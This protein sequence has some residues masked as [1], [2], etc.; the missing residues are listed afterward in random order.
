M[1]RTGG[2]QR[3]S[4]LPDLAVGLRRALHDRGP[5]AGLRRRR[6]R[7]GAPRVRQPDPPVRALTATTAPTAPAC[8]PAAGDQRR[9]LRPAAAR[10]PR[11]RRAVDR[12]AHR[13]RG[14][15]RRASRSSG[16]SA[17]PATRR[18]RL[19]RASR[20]RSAIVLDAARP[21]RPRRQR[22]APRRD[23][24]DPRR[25]RGV[26]RSATRATACRP[27]SRRSSAALYVVAAR[28]RRP[29]RRRGARTPPASAPLAVP[30]RASAAGS[31]SS[32]WRVGLRHRRVP[33]RQ[34]VRPARSS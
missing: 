29:A 12:R 4:Q 34:A 11:P 33:R 8:A 16:C 23:R 15:P 28:V 3:L 20:S 21:G 32:S 2:E 7:R 31:C 1:I 26:H 13:G 10:R 27:G 18:P 14:R 17:G 9:V 30:R 25:G 19:A 22:P 6:L 5:L 24:V